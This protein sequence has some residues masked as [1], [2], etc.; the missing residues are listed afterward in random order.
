MKWYLEGDGLP[1][2]GA[3]VNGSLLVPV[4]DDTS[5]RKY[6]CKCAGRQDKCHMILGEQMTC[7]LS[8]SDL[9]TCRSD[10]L[11]MQCDVPMMYTSFP[12]SVS[13]YFRKF[14]TRGPAH[15]R[16]GDEFTLVCEASGYP[17]PELENF[18]VTKP[19][20]PSIYFQQQDLT[21]TGSGVAVTV[22]NAS[23]ERHSGSYHCIVNTQFNMGQMHHSLQSGIS[24][25]VTVY[26][27]F[28][29]YACLGNSDEIIISCK[30]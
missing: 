22:T 1:L 4:A 29:E 9:N 12:G 10:S 19:S 13:P 16:S 11:Q 3:T 17:K 24:T 30:M 14:H 2:P 25:M 15:V 6:H 5:G 21:S 7:F 26:G 20:P 23:K 28:L 27:E 18:A 8:T